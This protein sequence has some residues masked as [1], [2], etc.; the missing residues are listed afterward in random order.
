VENQ[1]SEMISVN[2]MYVDSLIKKIQFQEEQLSL[3]D[4]QIR[5]LNSKIQ[6]LEDHIRSLESENR[7]L[8]DGL[9]ERD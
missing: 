1:D 5:I 6:N 3:K 8:T 2:K 9:N 4:D 7:E